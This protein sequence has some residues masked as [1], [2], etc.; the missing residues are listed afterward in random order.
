MTSSV[1]E[2]YLDKSIKSGNVPCSGSFGMRL[3]KIAEGGSS[4]PVLPV[5]AVG[6]MDA[7]I[8]VR[9]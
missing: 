8:A 1:T 9:L 6:G 4:Q 5:H 2:Q 7:M 3:A